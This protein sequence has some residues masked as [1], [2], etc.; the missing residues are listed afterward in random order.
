MEG[1]DYPINEKAVGVDI[2]DDHQFDKTMFNF[3][4]GDDVRPIIV[5]G[6]RNA[7]SIY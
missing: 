5:T 4:R 3:S 2:K 7:W 6:N 1:A